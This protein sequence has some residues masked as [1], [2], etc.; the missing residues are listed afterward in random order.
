MK[1]PSRHPAGVVAR[2]ASF[3]N[4]RPQAVDRARRRDA[5]LPDKR[6]AAIAAASHAA[7]FVINIRAGD[8]SEL[9]VRFQ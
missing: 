8:L 2:Q 5:D 9:G 3:A 7:A 6:G 4:I 1:A